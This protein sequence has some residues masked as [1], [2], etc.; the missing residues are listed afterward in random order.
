M[1]TMILSIFFRLKIIFSIFFYVLGFNKN[2][3]YPFVVQNMQVGLIR[4]DVFKELLKYPE[5]FFIKD[6]REGDS[7]VLFKCFKF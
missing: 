7:E 1:P 2:D 5:V 6:V 3:C 4:P